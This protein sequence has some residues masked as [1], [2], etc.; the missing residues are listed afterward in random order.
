VS[1]AE[2]RRIQEELRPRLQLTD[3]IRQEEVRT[4]AGVDNTYARSEA[5]TTAHAVVVALSF[6]GLEVVETSFA[7]RPVSFPYVPGLLAFREAPAVL[8]AFQRL[9]TEPDVIL[10]DGHGY[11]H[12]RRF[13]L[14]S[15]L[16]V[17]LDRPSIG[18]AK[19]RLV[20]R[21]EEPP[22]DFGAWTPIVEKGE[23]VGAALRTRPSHAPL[24]V[25]VGH[26]ISLPTAVQIV[27]A[28]CRERRFMPEPTRLAHQLVTDYARS[29]RQSS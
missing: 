5:G 4:V 16:G 9:P 24:F 11:A 22:R 15:H 6:P 29:G 3:A 23:T 20:G 28:C 2:A 19:S 27:L 10:F 1:P 25:S 7:S 14:A 12:P 8:D 13:G 18:C 21:Y 26:Q 17:V